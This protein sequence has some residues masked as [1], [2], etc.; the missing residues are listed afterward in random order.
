[1]VWVSLCL[2][3][4][5]ELIMKIR[6]ITV[7]F[8]LMAGHLFLP[9]LCRASSFFEMAFKSD[10]IYTPGKMN[11]TMKLT[12][13]VKVEG[14]YEFRVGIY[15]ADTLVRKQTL[16]VTKEE[17]AFFELTFPKAR[18]RMDVR[19]RAGLFLNGQFIEGQ[20][21]PL[22]VW[23]PLVPFSKEPTEKVIWVFDISG[24]L[25]IFFEQLEVK[26]V[27]ATFQAAR[28]FGAP[29]IVFIGECIDPNS[30]RVITHR[31]E[32]IDS[33][34]VVIFLRQKQL[35]ENGE[36]VIPK[37]ENRSKTVICDLNSPLLQ[38]LRKLDIMNMVDNASYLR[39]NKEKGKDWFIDSYVTEV[40]EKKGIHSYLLSIEEEDQVT[41]YCQLYLADCDD[42][43]YGILFNNLLKFAN[44]IVESKK[45]R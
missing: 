38:G 11:M 43:R 13:K 21:K 3:S 17:P 9:Q 6:I 28:D 32:S 23:P 8:T 16:P 29:D 12:N 35:L 22:T 45:N 25:Q 7:C 44:K 26:T 39:I 5:E 41:I 2:I 15:A 40:V 30:M 24:R 18:D 20:E 42:P 1:M 4:N 33:K 19:C 37:E 14:D 31:L 27:D 34:P 10:S 36:I